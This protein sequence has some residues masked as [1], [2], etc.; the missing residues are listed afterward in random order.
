MSG[1][2]KSFQ[3]FLVTMVAFTKNVLTGKDFMMDRR[4][5]KYTVA[6]TKALPE[7]MKCFWGSCITEV[8][9]KQTWG[10]GVYLSYHMPGMLP[11]KQIVEEILD[12]A[13]PGL[14]RCSHSLAEKKEKKQLFMTQDWVRI[15]HVWSGGGKYK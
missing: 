1:L 14:E 13:F 9:N 7:C 4:A 2:C 12:H 10:R 6:Q 8:S 3:G 5:A 11:S 15:R